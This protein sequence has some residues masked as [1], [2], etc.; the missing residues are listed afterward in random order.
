MTIKSKLEALT[1][2]IKAERPSISVLEIIDS[3]GNV[4]YR[5][6]YNENS[7]NWIVTIDSFLEK[8]E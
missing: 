3:S 4:C 2:T 5:M 6:E 1:K 7:D 8:I